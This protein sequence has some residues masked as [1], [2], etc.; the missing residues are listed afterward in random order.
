[1]FREG[2]PDF[3][4]PLQEKVLYD[5]EGGHFAYVGSLGTNPISPNPPLFISQISFSLM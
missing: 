5:R 1:M 2:V 4:F 3:H